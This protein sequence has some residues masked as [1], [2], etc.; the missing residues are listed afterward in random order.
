V[1]QVT[2]QQLQARKERAVRVTR[3]LLSDP[4]RSEEISE[5]RP[6]DHAVKRKFQITNPW[7]RRLRI[8]ARRKT[9]EDHRAEVADLKDEIGELAEENETLQA[10]LGQIADIVASEEIKE[11]GKAD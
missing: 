9:I 7:S 2:R 6:E 10:Q 5:E 8:M 4:E 3:D 11:E 1:K